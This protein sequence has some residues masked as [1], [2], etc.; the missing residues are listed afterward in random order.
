MTNDELKQKREALGFSQSE[1]ALALN[2]KFRTYQGW[3][4]G[5][6]MPSHIELAVAH[7][8]E[9]PTRTAKFVKEKKAALKAERKAAKTAQTT[10]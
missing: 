2:V 1:M 9:N 5:R 6:T 7:I 4:S 10:N 8:E 3:E